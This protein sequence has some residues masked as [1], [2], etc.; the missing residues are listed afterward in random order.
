MFT[1]TPILFR[2]DAPILAA[3]AAA[4]RVTVRLCRWNDV[5][6][7]RD[8]HGVEYREAYPPGSL[9]LAD[10]VGVLER[11]DT[12]TRERAELIGRADPDTWRPYDP[13]GPTVD[14]VLS[15]TPEAQRVLRHIDAGTLRAVSMEVEP[16]EHRDRDGIVERVAGKVHNVAFAFRPAHDAPILA[17]REQP[18]QETTMTTTPAPVPAPV[19]EPAQVTVEL[20]ERSIGELRD[21]LERTMLAAVP[22]DTPD[23]ASALL[24]YRSL[25]E[26]AEAVWADPANPILRRALADQTTD[27]GANAGVVPPG[28]LT[29]ISGI[30]DRGAP[31]ITAFGRAGLPAEG[32]DVNWPY[33]DGD[34]S[35]LVGEQATEKTAITSVVVDLKKGTEPIATYAGGSDVSYQLIRRSGPSYMAAYLRIMAIAYSQV[36]NTAMSASVSTSATASAGIWN[37][38]SGTLEALGEALFTAS[39]EVQAATGLPAEF[40]LASTDVFIAAGGLAVATATPYG[41]ESVP[42]HASA[43]N[44]MVTVAGLPVYHDPS[45]GAGTLIVSNSEAAT[46]Y[47]EGPFT[48]TAEDVEKLGQNVAVWGMGA[49][50]KPLPAGIRKVNAA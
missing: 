17:L 18:Q 47:A 30:I 44:L 12:D 33:F 21:D 5:R 20:L 31:T 49:T 45:Y 7:V 2:G 23:P 32:M 27:A 43:R 48:V 50:A 6:R 35:A 39:T 1:D 29:T 37:P 24:E 10:D 8:G 41:V 19:A 34:L 36:T 28:W 11:H 25:G 46:W 16:L 9:E 42:G 4:R 3:D 15:D 40:A 13:D 26:Y 14:L 38:S 22:A